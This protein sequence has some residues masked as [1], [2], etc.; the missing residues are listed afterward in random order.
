MSSVIDQSARKLAQIFPWG[1][2]R[3]YNAYIDYLKQRFGSRVQKV[4]VDAGFTC[5]NR[6]GSKG[7]GGCT[8]CNNDSFK[9]PYCLPNMSVADQVKEGI[10]FLSRRY[11]VDKFI[12]YFQSYSNTYASLRHL[13]KLYEE[14]LNH[15]QVI[16]LAVGTRSDCIDEQKI[17]YFS[18]LA[19]DY[20]VTLEYGL[21]SPYD[22]TLRW[23]RRMHDFE[24]WEKAVKLTAGRGIHICAHI[25]LGFPTESRDEMLKTAEIVSKY[26]IDYLKIHHLHV[27]KK[28]ILE[29][30]YRENPF[31]LPAYRDYVDLVTEF[32]QRLKPEIKV[33]RLVGETHPRILVVPNWGIRANIIQQHIEEKLAERDIWQGKLY[34]EIREKKIAGV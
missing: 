9:P 32:L 10:E 2:T 6:D 22:K 21:E 29:K 17:D 13:Q 23:I 31:P 11:K 28:T 26:P 25:I 19:R 5:P 34:R 30:I 27:V 24:S 16:G 14:A 3:R 7:V 8:Y 33:Q 1:T 12:V 4:I 18:Q 20:Y 15:P